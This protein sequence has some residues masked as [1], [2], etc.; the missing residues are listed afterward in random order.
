MTRTNIAENAVD[1]SV[2]EVWGQVSQRLRRELGEDTF[3]SWL[4]RAYAQDGGAGEAL[5]VTPSAF[6]RDWVRREA[7]KRTVQLWSECDPSGR[8]LALR[9]LAETG[10]EGQPARAPVGDEP[11]AALA[12]VPLAVTPPA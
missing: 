5:L 8:E 3:R 2:S 7:W 6:V 9:T 4:G 12:A 10:A 11:R 1:A